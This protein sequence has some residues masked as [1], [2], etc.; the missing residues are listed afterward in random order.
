MSS[1]FGPSFN[2][3]IFNS[4]AFNSNNYLTRYEADVLYLSVSNP[5]IQ[6]LTGVNP[7]SATASKALI[8]DSSVNI[9]G[10]NKLMIG[11]STD[12]S[13]NRFIS[14]LDSTISV[15]S[16]RTITFGYNNST[17]NQAELS[18]YYSNSASSYNRL[19]LGLNGNS[20]ILSLLPSGYV[21]IGNNNPNYKLDVNGII[22][23]NTTIRSSGNNLTSNP[24]LE[25]S[26]GVLTFAINYNS[27]TFNYIFIGTYTNH[28]LSLRVN[29]AEKLLVK[30][31]GVDVTGLFYSSTSIQT[32]RLIV[33]N[34]DDSSRAIC[35]LNSMSSG[36]KRYI[37]L[38]ENASQLN[39][40]EISFY[41][42]SGNSTTN[43][44]EF[45]MYGLGPVIWMTGT[46]R[47]YN[48]FN[49]SSWDVLSDERIKEDIVDADLD[50]CYN[51]IKNLRL[52]RYKWK[53]FIYEDK[54]ENLNYDKHR[55]GWIA[56]EVEPVFPNSVS[57][58]LL[59]DIDD[60]KTVNTDQIYTALYG[61]V[62][63]LIFDKEKLEQEIIELK[64][65][66]NNIEE[67]LKDAEISHD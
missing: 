4:S 49:Q 6:Y 30:S 42:Y 65:R 21:G 63:K 43:K 33:G 22:N 37:V 59:H 61:C 34:R 25:F 11:N 20:Q 56:Q 13:T 19:D 9:K 26:D 29:N 18:F 64:N 10:I 47:V 36:S 41:W 24:C 57:K 8:V 23:T 51:N 55:L 50:I 15:G 58:N 48:Y 17:Y 66:L 44:F 12:N 35:C 52:V 27:Y 60:C 39:Q 40:G 16:T 28:N 32:P 14:A 5:S 46:G 3:A 38:G 54:N 53:D 2:S 7:G 67:L 1:N 31:T 45:G 62:R